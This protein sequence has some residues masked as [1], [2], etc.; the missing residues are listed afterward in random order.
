MIE[1]HGMDQSN[2]VE[3]DPKPMILISEPKP[4]KTDKF[5]VSQLSE[6]NKDNATTTEVYDSLV[7]LEKAPSDIF[8]KEVI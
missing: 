7:G 5:R 3:D 1:Q 6:I 4:K 2:L 8:N